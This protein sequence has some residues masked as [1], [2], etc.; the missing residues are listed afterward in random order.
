MQFHSSFSNFF[1][2]G[3]HPLVI[4]PGWQWKMNHL[5]VIF[6]IKPIYSWMLVSTHLKNI[7]VDWDDDIPNIWENLENYPASTN[8]IHGTANRVPFCLWS[9]RGRG[10]SEC[11]ATK[12]RVWTYY[13]MIYPYDISIW[14]S[15]PWSMVYFLCNWRSINSAA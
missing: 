14:Y 6:L 10:P 9:Q 8:Q 13:S 5:S 3:A 11:L 4:K 15:S 1:P 12:P 2:F 7:S